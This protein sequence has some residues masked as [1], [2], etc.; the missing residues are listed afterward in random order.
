MKKIHCAACRKLVGVIDLPTPEGVTAMLKNA[1]TQK[2][3]IKTAMLLAS[4]Q[5]LLPML[6]PEAYD[7][8]L[9]AMP[10]YCPACIV[11]HDLLGQ[12]SQEATNASTQDEHFPSG[13]QDGSGNA[14]DSGGTHG[15]VHR[16]Q[17]G[18]TSGERGGDE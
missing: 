15:S 2:N 12:L 3:D 16:I 1:S 11:E 4:A 17:H 9:D 18:G 7:L 10:Q 6:P 14:G 5:T 8:L 13:I